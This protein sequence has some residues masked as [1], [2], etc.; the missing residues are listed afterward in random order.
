MVKLGA[1]VRRVINRIWEKRID[2]FGLRG[3]TTLSFL[4]GYFMVYS[5]GMVDVALSGEKR[6][7]MAPSS[8]RPPFERAQQRKK[9]PWIL[10]VIASI[11]FMAILAFVIV[12][13]LILQSQALL[14]ESAP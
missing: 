5:C 6:A 14:R 9:F 13:L 4:L 2:P 12:T 11:G 3:C 1:R 10:G 8:Q 7:I